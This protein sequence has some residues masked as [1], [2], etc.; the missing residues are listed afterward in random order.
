MIEILIDSFV[1]TSKMIPFLLFVYIGIEFVEYRWGNKIRIGIERAGKAGPFIGAVSGSFPQCGFSVL[2][3][4]LYT[5]RLVT[6]GTLIAVYLATSDEAIPIILSDPEKAHLVIPLIV[7][8]LLIAIVFG[9]FIDFI[10]RKKNKEIFEHA[11]AFNSGNDNTE[12]HHETLVDEHACCGHN[13]SNES[14]NFNFKEVFIHPIFHTMKIFVFI[15][16]TSLFIGF[17]ISKVGSDSLGEFFLKYQILQPFIAAI[18]GLIPNCASSVALTEL[19]LEGV[20]TYGAVIAG[21]SSA[22]GL[23]ILVLF[24]EEKNKKEVFKIIGILLAISIFVGLIIQL[25]SH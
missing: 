14:K 20:I 19:Y 16:V 3:T 25:I 5:Q 18:I 8:K 7:T 15:F 22:G 9:Y 6:I 23:G 2:T 24:R 12:H 11:N 10:F 21:L 17:I 4:A 1:D 13:L